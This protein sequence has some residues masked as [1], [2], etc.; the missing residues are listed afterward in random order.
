MRLLDVFK[1][2]P[3]GMTALALACDVPQRTLYRTAWAEQ[4]SA[5]W[6]LCEIA[7]AFRGLT[8]HRKRQ[9]RQELGWSPWNFDTLKS[10]W[11]EQRGRVEA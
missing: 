8:D 6:I 9:I 2:Y 10:A 5:P 1:L 11:F 3:G 4:K 7:D